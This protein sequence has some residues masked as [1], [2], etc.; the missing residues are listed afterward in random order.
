MKWPNQ[1]WVGCFTNVLTGQVL[2]V[3]HSLSLEDAKDYDK[4]NQSLKTFRFTKDG[5]HER[6]K[7]S[8]PE[9][10]ENFETFVNSISK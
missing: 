9:N 1:E 8:K 5:F 4:V 6:F 7:K 10:D 2:N 3:L